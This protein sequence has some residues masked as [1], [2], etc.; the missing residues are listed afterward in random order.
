MADAVRRMRW[1]SPATLWR[2]EAFGVHQRLL[3]L[4]IG[5]REVEVGLGDLDVVAEDLI[6]ADLERL[7]ADAGALSLLHLKDVA[8]AVLLQVAQLVQGGIHAGADHIA[9]GKAEWRLIGK[10][11]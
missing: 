7:D 4:V 10:R 8:A 11:G 2:G 6:E 3:A 9:V 1:A 5:G